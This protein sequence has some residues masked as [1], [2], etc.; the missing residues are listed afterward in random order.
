[1]LVHNLLKLT[2][3]EKAKERRWKDLGEEM[4][5]RRLAKT[6]ASTKAGSGEAH[7]HRQA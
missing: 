6:F 3:Q 4:C 5:K 2:F 1:M 7:R